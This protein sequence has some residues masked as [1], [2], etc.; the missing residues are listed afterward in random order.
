MMSVSVEIDVDYGQVFDRISTADLRTYLQLKDFAA[1]FVGPPHRQDYHSVRM[2][3]IR[4]HEVA[5]EGYAWEDELLEETGDDRIMRYVA[6]MHPER[7]AETI[8]IL[9]I[10]DELN[11]L[12]D[13]RAD[14]KPIDGQ[15]QS[16]GWKYMNRMVIYAH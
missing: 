5:L 13:A 3:R 4:S 11:R 16:I 8:K 9:P 14:G 15:L 6:A 1:A 2:S 10:A 12:L 7:L